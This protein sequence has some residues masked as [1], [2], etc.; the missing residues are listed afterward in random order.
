MV[1]LR[2][3][4]QDYPVGVL[5]T[6]KE[7]GKVLF[8]NAAALTLL[9]CPFDALAGCCLPELLCELAHEEDLDR[10]KQVGEALLAGEK[11]VEAVFRLKS[12]RDQPFVTVNSEWQTSLQR[13]GRSAAEGPRVSTW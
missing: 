7:T 1:D 9:G 8:A 3:L 13:T 2:C 6:E 4:L 5:L 12:A 10:A 11:T